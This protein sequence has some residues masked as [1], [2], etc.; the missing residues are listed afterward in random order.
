MPVLWPGFLRE[1]LDG[2]GNSSRM[3]G[4]HLEPVPIFPPAIGGKRTTNFRMGEVHHEGLLY[5]QH[6]KIKANWEIVSQ[7][8]PNKT[9]SEYIYYWLIVNTR[10]FYFDALGGPIP[11]SHDDRMVMCPFVDYFNHNDHGVSPGR[12]ALWY[13]SV[14]SDSVM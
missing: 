8:F 13:V 9:L 6:R 5:Q 2:T 12:D 1:P 11:K 4:L 14:L 3:I 7:V 10:S